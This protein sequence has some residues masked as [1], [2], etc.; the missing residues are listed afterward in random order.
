MIVD[1]NIEKIITVNS[2]KC[3]GCNKCVKVCPIK[4]ANKT[5]L[6][7]NTDDQFITEVN[8]DM[9]INCGECVKACKHGARN[10][11]DHSKVFFDMF[12]KGEAINIIVA[13][14]IKTAFPYDMWKHMLQWRESAHPFRCQ[15]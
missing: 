1:N 13:P 4:V 3:I 9:C 6:K 11:V 12:E 7:P 8:P 10:Y 14:A 5:V 2:E 15:L